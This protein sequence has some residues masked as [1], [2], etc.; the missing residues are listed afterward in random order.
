MLWRTPNNRNKVTGVLAVLAYL[1]NVVPLSESQQK[2]VNNF[3]LSFEKIAE[4]F[5]TQFCLM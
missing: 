1:S 3:Y 2:T 5:P 4:G